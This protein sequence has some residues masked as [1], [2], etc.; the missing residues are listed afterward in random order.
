M[1]WSPDKNPAQ[2][3][4]KTVFGKMNRPRT[5]NF[6][7]DGNDI[8]AEG[9]HLDVAN[10]NPGSLRMPIIFDKCSSELF[11]T[12]DSRWKRRTYIAYFGMIEFKDG[13]QVFLVKCPLNFEK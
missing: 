1:V 4:A 6:T 8:I 13:L 9:L 3:S 7:V 12:L 10:D 11:D 5:F 2:S